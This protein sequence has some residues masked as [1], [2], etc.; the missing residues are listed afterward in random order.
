LRTPSEDG[1][2]KL[3]VRT[4]EGDVEFEFSKSGGLMESIHQQMNY[5]GNYADFKAF[6]IVASNLLSI[7]QYTS[8]K[9]FF[10]STAKLRRLQADNNFC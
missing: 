2:P 4:P 3:G 8:C 1:R 6:S 7:E 9:T 5:G 10:A